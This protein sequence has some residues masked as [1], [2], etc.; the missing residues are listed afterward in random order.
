MK[1]MVFFWLL[2]LSAAIA[3]NGIADIMA[4][5]EQDKR[6]EILEQKCDS[7]QRQIDFMV[8]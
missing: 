4:D 2:A 5:T 8:E 3:L 1:G 6:T 7:L